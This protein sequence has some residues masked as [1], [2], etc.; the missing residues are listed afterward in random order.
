MGFSIMSLRLG[1]EAPNFTANTTIGEIN[2]HEY[3]KDSWGILFS[4]PADFTPVCTTE[5]G[6]VAKLKGEFDKRNCK[7]LGYS[8]NSTESHNEWIKDINDVN[9]CEMNFPIVEGN[10]RAIAVAYGML[11]PDLVD[12]AGLPFTVRSVFVINPEK[13]V[14]LILTYP[15][16]TGRNFTEVLRCLDSLQMDPKY[17]LATPSDWQPGDDCVILPSVS[18]EEAD[19]MFPGNRV[20]RPY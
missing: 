20:V 18:Q 13:I 16:T 2:F 19:K 15:A 6:A 17:K 7:V 5:L 11:D 12:E 14:K 3:L 1:D 9:N 10:D 4:H 8:C